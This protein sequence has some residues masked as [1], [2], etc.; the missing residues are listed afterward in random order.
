MES[1]AGSGVS[2]AAMRLIA[3][4]MRLTGAFSH[5][6]EDRAASLRASWKQELRRTASALVYALVAAFFICSA[7]A[8]G[9]FALMMA[10]WE[11]HR[12]LV[13]SLLSGAFL[14][15]AVIVLLLLRRDTR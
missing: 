14:L 11:T 3:T 1:E 8:W 9:A 2:G 12:V 4:L 6:V 7:A 13:A 15:L 10:F 5:F